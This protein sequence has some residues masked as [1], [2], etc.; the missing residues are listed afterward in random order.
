MDAVDCGCGHG[1]DVLAFAPL[2]RTI[3]GYDQI[4]EFIRIAEAARSAKGIEN[5][6]FIAADSSSSANGG[7]ACMPL[8]SNAIDLFLS[9]RGPT[10][11]VEDVPR[12]GRPGAL[13]VQLSP[14]PVV[15]PQWM[16]FVP[17][18]LLSP[19]LTEPV[20][21]CSLS[22]KLLSRIGQARIEI[23]SQRLVEAPEWFP[24]PRDLYHFLTWGN[25]QRGVPAYSEVATSLDLV[26]RNHASSKGLEYRRAGLIWEGTVPA[27]AD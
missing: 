18:V 3:V 14:V 22:S 20:L 8:G 19:E 6:T 7:G 12:V 13:I 24:S 16:Q 11:W 23:T 27:R 15:P 10:H 5:A 9:R 25:D 2:V 21:E 17:S 26:F 1:E 4:V